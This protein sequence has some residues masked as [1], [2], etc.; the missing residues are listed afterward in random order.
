MPCIVGSKEQQRPCTGP[1]PR[2]ICCNLE[3]FSAGILSHL[4][5]SPPCFL[6]MTSHAL[7][8]K[9]ALPPHSYHDIHPMLLSLSPHFPSP[10]PRPRHPILILRVEILQIRIRR[11][12]FQRRFRLRGRL[13]L[14]NGII[15]RPADAE[16]AL[17]RRG[18]VA[19]GE[20]R[21]PTH[22]VGRVVAFRCA[23]RLQGDFAVEPA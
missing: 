23:R 10:P 14:P 1:S 5:S 15:R 2:S 22:D 7:L 12:G 11:P 19:D 13:A 4:F 8:C 18:L 6:S 9:L 17:I 21:V 20:P 16:S 3:R